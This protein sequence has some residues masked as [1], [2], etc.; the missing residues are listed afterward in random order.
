MGKIEVAAKKNGGDDKFC[1]LVIFYTILLGLANNIFPP[2]PIPNSGGEI[3][4]SSL[5]NMQEIYAGGLWVESIADRHFFFFCHNPQNKEN[6]RKQTNK[7]MN[8][9]FVVFQ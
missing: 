1:L 2:S 6:S 9:A 7:T 8:S 4:A 5:G 3:W